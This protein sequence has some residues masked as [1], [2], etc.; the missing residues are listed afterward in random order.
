MIDNK[1]IKNLIQESKIIS[2]E[3]FS[4]LIMSKLPIKKKTKVYSYKVF[5]I[6]MIVFF[7]NSYLINNLD[8]NSIYIKSEYIIFIF[9]TIGISGL[10]YYLYNILEYRRL[11]DNIF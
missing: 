6:C 5:S 2:D 9:N 8:Y 4:D 10:L 1:E 11:E 3:D 7:I